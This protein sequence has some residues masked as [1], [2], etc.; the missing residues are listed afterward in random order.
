MKMKAVMFH[1]AA[2]QRDLRGGSEK[3][4]C[5]ANH[6]DFE[7]IASPGRQGAERMD[8]GVM[9][10]VLPGDD[11][12]HAGEAGVGVA[13]VDAPDEKAVRRDG[14]DRVGIARVGWLGDQED[15][16]A[17]PELVVV[18]LRPQ[19]QPS[20]LGHGETNG[21]EGRHRRREEEERCCG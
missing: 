21:G 13:L 20:Q 14:L 15:C 16:I 1:Q 5:D 8:G 9:L 17:A 11:A 18:D 19:P 10:D 2:K 4:D 3:G 6:G 12:K 7:A